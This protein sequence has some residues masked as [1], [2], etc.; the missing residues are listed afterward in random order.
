M[1]DFC[2]GKMNVWFSRLC[3]LNGTSVAET[4]SGS[5]QGFR[6]DLPERER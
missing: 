4:H 1:A 3:S 5:V 6:K 2:H